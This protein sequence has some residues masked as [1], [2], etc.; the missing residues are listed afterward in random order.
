MNDATRSTLQ[1]LG[2]AGTVTG[3]R[4]LIEAD[5]QRVLVDCGRFPALKPL[6]GRSH[7]SAS[8]LLHR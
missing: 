2:A 4:Y 3:S 8:D 1:F 7:E 5:G 6:L